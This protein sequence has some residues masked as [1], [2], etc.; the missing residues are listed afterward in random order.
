MLQ[1]KL[2]YV[3]RDGEM[4]GP[5]LLDD[6]NLLLAHRMVSTSELAWHSTVADW[7]PLS[8]LIRILEEQQLFRLSRFLRFMTLIS[9]GRWMA[10]PSR[11]GLY[12]LKDLIGTPPTVSPIAKST[13]PF[14]ERI[15]S[16]SLELLNR[17]TKQNVEDFF[18]KHD[19]LPCI[20]DDCGGGRVRITGYDSDIAGLRYL[21][22][23]LV[24]GLVHKGTPTGALTPYQFSVDMSSV[25]PQQL[26]TLFHPY[27]TILKLISDDGKNRVYSA[28]NEHELD[29]FKVLL[30]QNI[31]N[32]RVALYSEPPIQATN[33][34]H[35]R[36]HEAAI[37]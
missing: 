21:A 6:L 14:D 24:D 30:K 2:F 17:I 25:T 37:S 34:L 27:P 5:F 28:R 19:D 23:R 4:R 11:P 10:K 29:R 22:K 18:K 31:P 32:I 9:S 12:G 33:P 16:F 15:D 7:Q 8:E 26:D 36:R 13:Q 20:I 35:P 1:R 3:A